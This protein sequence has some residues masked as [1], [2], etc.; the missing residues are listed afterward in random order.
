MSSI[1]QIPEAER[2]RFEQLCARIGVPARVAADAWSV[3]VQRYAE[4][5]NPILHPARRWS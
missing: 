5:S 2:R 1:K 3:I 4:S